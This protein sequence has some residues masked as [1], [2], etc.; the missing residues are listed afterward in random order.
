MPTIEVLL[1]EPDDRTAFARIDQIYERAFSK[2]TELCIATA[3]LT[4]WQHTQASRPMNL[5]CA[6]FMFLIGTDF[7]LT[8]KAAIQS[9]RRWAPSRLGACIYAVDR[10]LRWNFHPKMLL[11]R[12]M[13]GTFHAF[14]GSSNITRG[15]LSSNVEANVHVRLSAAHYRG[16]RQTLL[17]IRDSAST[18]VDP[19]W[20]KGYREADFDS[21]R[22]GA[23]SPGSSAM[24]TSEFALPRFSASTMTTKLSERRHQKRL[25]SKSKRALLSA[26][27]RCANG[28]M[29]FDAFYAK[30]PSLWQG[31]FQAPGYERQGR[32]ANWR[33]ACSA[34][35]RVVRRRLP[36]EESDRAVAEEINRL[37]LNRNAL[38]GAWLSE[39][40]CQFQPDRYPVLNNPVKEWLKAR[41]IRKTRG[42]SVGQYY[43][44]VAR[45]LRVAVAQSRTSN[46]ATTPQDLAEAD[47]LIWIDASK[48]R[49]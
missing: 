40:L 30:L 33:E 27:T 11:W 34:L 9:V 36:L 39:M 47:H 49:G 16:L 17:H 19:R 20:L 7:G 6:E 8:R 29:A 25:F 1:T 18:P 13:D 24:R 10:N 14:V 44:E 45:R 38:R 48:V 35:V 12:E 37:A 22:Q 5:S 28:R 2:A 43:V 32:K 4:A 3:Y 15:G 42:M 46:R 21:R 41:G 26:A 23:G 31:R